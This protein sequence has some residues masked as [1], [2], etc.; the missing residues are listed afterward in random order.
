MSLTQMNDNYEG[1]EFMYWWHF[2]SATDS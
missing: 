1:E 2:S